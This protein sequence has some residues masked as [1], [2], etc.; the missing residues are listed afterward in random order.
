MVILFNKIIIYD[1]HKNFMKTDCRNLYKLVTNT[2]FILNLQQL[3][4]SFFLLN[5]LKTVI[6]KR[7]CFFIK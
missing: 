5:L 7:L 3:V 2:F 6:Q 1:F 4:Y